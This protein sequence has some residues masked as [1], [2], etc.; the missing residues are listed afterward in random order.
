VLLAVALVLTCGC[1]HPP[2]KPAR[3]AHP[4]TKSEL[5]LGLY[6]VFV[7]VATAV[8]GYPGRDWAPADLTEATQWLNCDADAA[9]RA[10]RIRYAVTKLAAGIVVLQRTGKAPLQ[11]ARLQQA[12]GALIGET[13][14]LS[15]LARTA[16]ADLPTLEGEAG[17]IIDASTNDPSLTTLQRTC[18]PCIDDCVVGPSTGESIA[19]FVIKVN[20]GPQ[21]LFHVI[22]PQCWPSVV[23]GYVTQTFVVDNAPS[24]TAGTPTCRSGRPCDTTLPAPLP[25]SSPP[26]AG[27]PWCGLLFEDVQTP[28]NGV[29]GRFKNV[30]KVATSSVPPA[31][32]TQ[33]GFRMDYGLCESPYWQMCDQNTP[34]PEGTCGVTRDCGFALVDDTGVPGWA[35]L[36]GT[37]R[38][39]FKTGLPHDANLW[40][41]LALE[42][43]VKETALATC[44]PAGNCA[45]AATPTG[46]VV[47][48]GPEKCVCAQDLC[49]Q[50]SYVSP[51][52]ESPFCQ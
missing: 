17:Q 48:P 50:K 33:T 5:F 35:R 22:D 36:D 29:T 44:V 47:L 7:H 30:L 20:R 42:V 43:L 41:P 4:S 21:C 26:K 11:V 27:T 23:P 32:A 1:R 6:S 34:C 25:Q 49:I 46:C 12:L 13:T 28:A 39:E 31:P 38:I 10:G 8:S 19:E 2:P 40:A 15:K 24:C 45:A 18:C 3:C 16:A 9:S 51:I 52:K 37:K 14:L